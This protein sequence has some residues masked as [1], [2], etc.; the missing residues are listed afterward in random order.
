VITSSKTRPFPIC[1][2][3]VDYLNFARHIR[4]APVQV[5]ASTTL[6][7]IVDLLLETRATRFCAHNSPT[8]SSIGTSVPEQHP[9]M[10]SALEHLKSQSMCSIAKMLGGFAIAPTMQTVVVD[11]IS[12]VD[13]Q[14]ASIIGDNAEAV[15]ASPSDSQGS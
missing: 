1:V 12:I 3:V 5:L 10:T 6:P 11:C 14:L 4:S 8:I 7:K 9:S 13:P 2:A 15:V